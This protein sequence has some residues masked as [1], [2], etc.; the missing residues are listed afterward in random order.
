MITC[1]ELSSPFGM[2]EQVRQLGITHW[3][4]IYFDTITGEILSD[5]LISACSDQTPRQTTT[6]AY[7]KLLKHQNNL[8][9]IRTETIIRR[10]VGREQQDPTGLS[11]QCQLTVLSLALQT[12]EKAPW[13]MTTCELGMMST[14]LQFFVVLFFTKVLSKMKNDHSRR[15]RVKFVVVLGR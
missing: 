12:M 6:K 10:T 11:L 7:R 9:R 15:F 14:M 3:F 8:E 5:M 4:K 1:V 13:P 2:F